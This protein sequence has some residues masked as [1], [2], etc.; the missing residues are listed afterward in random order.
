[1][2]ASRRKS[3]ALFR[4]LFLWLALATGA[5]AAAAD[6]TLGVLAFR[7]EEAAV[8]HWQP[9]ADYL[10]RELGDHQVH[11]APLSLPG[12]TA[13]LE[14]G[15]ID[16]LLTNPGHARR[17]AARYRMS[18]LATLR[19]DRPGG[20]QTGNRFGAVIFTRADRGDIRTVS[21]LAG[22]S[23]AA[24][25]PDAFGGYKMAAQTMLRNG[26]DPERDLGDR[27]FL[28]FPQRRIVEA[29]LAGEADAGTVRTGMLEAMTQAGDLDLGRL[30]I[31]NPTGV[32]GFDPLLS[33]AVFPEWPMLSAWGTDEN[34]RRRVV[35]AL[36]S[37][38]AGHPAAAAGGYGGWIPPMNDTAVAELQA[39]L[40]AAAESPDALVWIVNLALGLA[41]AAVAGLA[42]WRRAD[43]VRRR[44]TRAAPAP[45]PAVHL[46]PR[47]REILALIEKGL[48][49]KK[50]A[51][52]LGI[53]PKTVEFHRGH[54]MR[55]FEVRNMAE[56]VHK[57][58][59]VQSA[60]A[61]G[62][63]LPS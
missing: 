33:T 21:D 43:S 20:A 22:R 12:V 19:T 1:M 54:L 41:L 59:A 37:M 18:P 48:T 53:S 32:P 27:L 3:A 24:V 45:E 10:S 6:L 28:G 39:E 26:I 36:L 44:R 30:R 35:I 52:D 5:P 38:P 29:V 46:T 8:A 62:R 9:T 7:G 56:L 58:A 51:R 49:T 61:E 34:L 4:A 42:I 2:M 57:S 55:K 47:E 40:E 31:L 17:L 23:F 14:S 13:A 60:G 11:L 15:Q 25:A 50:I 16:L 63:P